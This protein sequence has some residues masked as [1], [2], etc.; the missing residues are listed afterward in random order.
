MA[1]KRP[2]WSARF[3]APVEER[4]KRFTASVGFDRRLA[5]YD[6]QGSRAHARML[7]ARR[8]LSRRDL[9]AIQ[10]GLARIERQIEAGKF[11]WSLYPEGVHLNIERR[12]TALM[13]DA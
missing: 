12:M 11:R 9:A 1:K 10:P 5:K 13:D 2:T 7:A 8:I 6:I 3:A 4:V